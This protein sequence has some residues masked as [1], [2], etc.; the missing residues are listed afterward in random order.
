FLRWPWWAGALLIII[1]YLALNVVFATLYWIFGGVAGMHARAYGE[2]FSFSIQTMGT[3]GYGAMYPQSRTANILVAA[4]SITGL[5]ATAIA[6]GL[7]FAKVSQSNA[8]VT[9]TQRATIA[10]MD[11]VPTLAFR[12]GNERQNQ[13]YE[14]TMRV[15][16]MRNEP[17]AEGMQ[18]YRMHDL[19][20]I[21]ERSPAFSRSWT[22]MHRIVEGSPLFGETAAS[23]EATDT[24][25]LAALVGVDDTSMQPVHA[26]KTF[27]HSE[28]AWGVR[29]ADVLTEHPDGTLTVDLTK[30]DDVVEVRA[31]A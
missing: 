16:L 23:L 30:W 4:E 14:A 15:V 2:A 26:R 6:T 5:L 24:E 13:I 21:R 20:L 29:H 8:R 11:G 31:K 22:V 9:F 27:H 1:S 25:I 19:K 7:T 28:V 12:V 18:F 3:I 17:T 10:L